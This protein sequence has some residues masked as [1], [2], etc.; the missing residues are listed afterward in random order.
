MIIICDV[1]IYIH[2]IIVFK[3]TKAEIA[4]NYCISLKN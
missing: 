4:M 1:Y 2:T 3:S